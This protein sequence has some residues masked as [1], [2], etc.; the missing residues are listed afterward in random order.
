VVPSLL[1][2]DK[3][4]DGPRESGGPIEMDTTEAFEVEGFLLNAENAGVWSDGSTIGTLYENIRTETKRENDEN[5]RQ[6]EPP[7]TKHSFQD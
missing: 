5:N 3:E 7:A 6:R 4:H 2:R 1:P